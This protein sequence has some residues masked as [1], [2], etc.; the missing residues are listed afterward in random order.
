M[1]LMLKKAWI[2]LVVGFMA[3]VLAL[4]FAVLVIGRVIG[5]AWAGIAHLL[6]LPFRKRDE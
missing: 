6:L 5:D 1:L 4:A 3:I 2:S